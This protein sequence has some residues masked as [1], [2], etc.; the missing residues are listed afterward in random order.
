[1]QTEAEN[2]PDY[3]IIGTQWA[4][5]IQVSVS[6]SGVVRI[7]QDTRGGSNDTDVI[8]LVSLTSLQRLIHK[9]QIA[10]DK[11]QKPRSN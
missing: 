11:L 8:L 2:N 10:S 6:P 7:V 1:M 4:D 9:L 5:G 3:G